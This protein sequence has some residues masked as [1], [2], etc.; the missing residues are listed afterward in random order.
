VCAVGRLG[1]YIVSLDWAAIT[2]VVVGGGGGGQ[3][4]VGGGG[5]GGGGGPFSFKFFF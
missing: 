4:G 3:G 1:I 2:A 5:G